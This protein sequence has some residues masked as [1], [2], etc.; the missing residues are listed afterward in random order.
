MM[1]AESDD[2]DHR[3]SMVTFV[4]AMIYHSRHL[5][6]GNVVLL[7]CCD[8]TSDIFIQMIDDEMVIMLI[9]IMIKAMLMNFMLREKF[10]L[11]VGRACN[12]VGS[13]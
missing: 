12:K 13:R 7:S 10:V 4:T 1:M 11:P 2:D 3:M 9:M 6:L 8:W 5:S